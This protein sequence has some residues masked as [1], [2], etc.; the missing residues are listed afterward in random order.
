MRPLSFFAAIFCLLPSNGCRLLSTHPLHQSV[1]PPASVVDVGGAVRDPQSVEIPASGLNLVQAITRAG[2]LDADQS[3]QDW[4]VSLQRLNH[5]RH[6]IYWMPYQL[7][8]QEVAGMIPLRNG[9]IVQVVPFGLTRLGV[10]GKSTDTV[11]VA[12]RGYIPKPGDYDVAGSLADLFSTDSAGG[13]PLMYGASVVTLTRSV[14]LTTEHYVLPLTSEVIGASPAILAAPAK[15]GDVIT[16]T[17]MERIPIVLSGF[18]EDLRRNAA[19][20]VRGRGRRVAAGGGGLPGMSALRAAS[21]GV[22]RVFQ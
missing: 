7:V 2:S 3:Q 1:E 9:D 15:Q 4:F 11:R 21:R 18:V 19:A 8:N 10:G 12:L 20:E 22:V 6:Q 14:G 17:R 5:G 16:F 13:N